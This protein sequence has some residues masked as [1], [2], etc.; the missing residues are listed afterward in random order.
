MSRSFWK[1]K[2]IPRFLFFKFKNL[3]RPSYITCSLRNI[4][5]FSHFLNCHFVCYTG[6]DD[7]VFKVNENVLKLKL[8]SFVITRKFGVVHIP[9][10][11]KKQKELEEQKRKTKSKLESKN[12]QKNKTKKKDKK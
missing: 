5:L 4:Y 11:T 7:F 6:C 8:S 3:K 2:F 1:G 10:K 9:K 12:K